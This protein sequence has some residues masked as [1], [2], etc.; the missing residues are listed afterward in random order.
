VASGTPSIH[1]A[2]DNGTGTIIASSVEGADV[3]I[4]AEFTKLIQTQRAYEANTKV[5]TT[6]DTLLQM[7]DNLIR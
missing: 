1:S 3:D 4:A 6:T 7:T 5:I 2:G